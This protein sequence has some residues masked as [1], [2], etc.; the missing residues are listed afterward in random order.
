M[1]LGLFELAPIHG[2]LPID[3]VAPAF[4][5]VDRQ[6]SF[7]R[8]RYPVHVERVRIP[9]PQAQ[10]HQGKPRQG[11]RVVGIEGKGLL[12]QLPR[13]MPIRKA[14]SGVPVSRPRFC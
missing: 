3:E 5:H 10:P 7:G 4:G 1:M 13:W 12:K 9:G 14:S 8:F 2:D 6:G 11:E